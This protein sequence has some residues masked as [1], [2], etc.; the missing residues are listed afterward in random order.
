MNTT[1]RCERSD[2]HPHLSNEIQR[3]GGVGVLINYSRQMKQRKRWFHCD[4]RP[5]CYDT[6]PGLPPNPYNTMDFF[7]TISSMVV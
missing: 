7:R 2:N 5:A 6:R 4:T 1:L 3:N